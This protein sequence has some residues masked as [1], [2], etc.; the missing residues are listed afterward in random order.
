MVKKGFV[1]IVL[2][3]LLRQRADDEK[4]GSDLLKVRRGLSGLGLSVVFPEAGACAAICPED[5]SVS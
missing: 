1:L 4:T 2:R 5:F 3:V